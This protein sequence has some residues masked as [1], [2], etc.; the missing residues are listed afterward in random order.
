[1]SGFRLREDELAV[2]DEGEAAADEEGEAGETGGDAEVPF[3]SAPL[4][5][6]ALRV[7]GEAVTETVTVTEAVAVAEAVTETETEAVTV[8]V[9]E[10]EAVPE[11]EAEAEGQ[12]DAIDLAYSVSLIDAALLAIDG[13]VE[14]PLDATLE[15]LL[16]IRERALR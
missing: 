2:L 13:A 6:A 16:A 9:T 12:V 10:T 15:E 11:T 5:G 8:T 4:R 14:V 3:D 7:S 1:M